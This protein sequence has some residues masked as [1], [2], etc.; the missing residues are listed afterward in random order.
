MQCVILQPK[1]T[2][3]NANIPT[4]VVGFPTAKDIGGVLRRS[5]EPE[6]IGVWKWGA[7]MIHLF[8]YKTGKA[9][10]ENKHE[11]PPPHDTILLFGE[12]VLVAS[13]GAASQPVPATFT[14]T[15]FT[16]FYN[17]AMNGFED[18]E[19]TAEADEDLDSD[20]DEE[21]LDSDAEEEEEEA[22]E[23]AAEE[24]EEETEEVVLEE[25]EEEAPPPVKI[26]KPVK[27]TNK[28]TPTWFM[29]PDLLPE[30]Y[31][32][33]TAG[34]LPTVPARTTA[35]RRIHTL[36]GKFITEEQEILLERGLYNFALEESNRK[37][38][39]PLWENSEFQIL[40][41]IQLTR[42]I[43]NLMAKSYVSNARLLERLRDGEFQIWEVPYMTFSDLY[44]ERWNSLAEREMKKESKMLEVDKTMATDMFRC[45]R[46]GKRQCT[47]YEQQTRSADEP[48]T[49]FVRCL[50]CSKQ[51]RQ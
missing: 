51:W 19:E 45:P 7:T 34:L 32:T 8:G 47:Y 42:V 21:G 16:K 24:S 50:N 46:C 35:L 23:D 40:Y 3:R 41:D 9:A 36:L 28:K 2:T 25:E 33:T 22:E 31:D 11:L 15:Q 27:R 20:D 14:V 26:P 17:E 10:T 12:A 13:T 37:K 5:T 18:L 1:G 6:K 44:P 43:S 39:R 30:S 29:L 4:T 38:T 49:I 48:M